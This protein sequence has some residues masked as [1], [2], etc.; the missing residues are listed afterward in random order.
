MQE[1]AA[2]AGR[3]SLSS[4]NVRDKCSMAISNALLGSQPAVPGTLDEVR[5]ESWRFF[6]QAVCR[7]HTF[8]CFHLPESAA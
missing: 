5:L 3:V 6:D 8:N 2:A 1:S 4:H 7:A